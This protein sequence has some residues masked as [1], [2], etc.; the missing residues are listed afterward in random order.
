MVDRELYAEQRQYYSTVLGEGV[1]GGRPREPSV[2]Y[3]HRK[4]V[5]ACNGLVE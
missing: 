5:R 3:I 4:Y 1:V 2:D